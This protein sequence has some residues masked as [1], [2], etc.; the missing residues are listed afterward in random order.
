MRKNIFIGLIAFIVGLFACISFAEVKVHYPQY[1][2][3]LDL[4][5]ETSSSNYNAKRQH[6]RPQTTTRTRKYGQSYQQRRSYSEGSAYS[7]N[8]YRNRAPARQNYYRSDDYYQNQ[9]SQSTQAAAPRERYQ[10]ILCDS[11][12]YECITVKRGESWEKL[13]PDAK[14]RDIVRRLNRLNIRLWAGMRIAVPDNL[15]EIGILDISP[16]DK[17]IDTRGQK[18]II[19]DLSKQAWAAYDK[20]GDLAHWGPASGGRDY[21]PDINGPCNTIEG[22]FAVFNKKDQHCKS[23]SFPVDRGGGSP[24]PYCMFFHAGFAIHGSYEVPGYNASHGCVRVYKK[25]AKWLNEEFVELPEH[26]FD[27]GTEVIV[28]A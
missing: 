6:N 11:G 15:E 3:L 25:D 7:G 22:V 16:F 18:L 4:M 17:S 9:S 23:G 2:G 10:D 20:S 13:F 12:E 28:K 8:Y 21:C 19:V 26:Q 27:D 5:N 1:A 24:M 14:Q